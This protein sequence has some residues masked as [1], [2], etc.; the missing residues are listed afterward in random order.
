MSS[1][2]LNE[3]FYHESDFSFD[4]IEP[5]YFTTEMR[6][7]IKPIQCHIEDSI[8][9]ASPP[10][11]AP[12]VVPPSAP[13]SVPIS[14]VPVSAPVTVPISA[15]LAAPVSVP[16]SAVPVSAPVA[17]PLS[18]PSR[19]PNPPFES[20]RPD[21]LFWAIFTHVYGIE[22]Y[23]YI[24]HSYGNR[25]LEEKTKIGSHIKKNAA[26]FKTA[27]NYKIT[28]IMIQEIQSE[29]MTMHSK[30]SHIEIIAMAFFYGIEIALCFENN[31]Y[32]T[33]GKQDIQNGRENENGR[34]NDNEN[35]INPLC[36]IYVKGTSAKLE[37]EPCPE[38]LTPM[39]KH[40]HYLKP[41]NTISNYKTDELY[42]IHHRLG[43]PVLS[44]KPKKQDIY[45]GIIEY[46]V[47]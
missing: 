43:M 30:T 19:K 12:L 25:A 16:I 21:K 45:H 10:P 27:S 8:S 2:Y 5:F 23:N 17:V 9:V 29:L 32:M 44:H 18:V 11:S 37:M 1:K 28:N 22:E 33:F 3:L 20:N 6:N 4:K 41:L 26:A 13:V 31:T 34:E 47:K 38:I 7:S 24:G 35:D 36:I 40:H 42:D 39:F 15:A 46:L 14:A